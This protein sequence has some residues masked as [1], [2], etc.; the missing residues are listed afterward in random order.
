ALPQALIAG[1]PVV[2]F[3]VDGAREVTVD[4]QTGFLI[5][6]RQIAPLADALIRLAA[7][8][9]LRRRLGQ[10]GRDRFTDVFRHQTMTRRVREQYQRVLDA[11][12]TG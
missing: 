4:D 8:A 2:S 7:D 11:S 3:D 1:K 6:P 5:P 10:T 9:D 12:G